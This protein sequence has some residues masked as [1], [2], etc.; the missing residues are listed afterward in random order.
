ME[1]VLES[2]L[3][4]TV[5]SLPGA[6]L[7]G[8]AVATRWQ[9]VRKRKELEL[10]AAQSFYMQY[11]EF[12]AI[13]KIWDQLIED[14]KGDVG[15]VSDV[16]RSQLLERASAMEGGIEATLLK[17][18]SE[19]ALCKR[20]RCHLGQLRQ[21]FGVVRYCIRHRM[22]IPYY[23]SDVDLYLRLKRLSTTFGVLLARPLAH[24]PL[25]VFPTIP[26]PTF[27]EAFEAWRDITSNEHETNWKGYLRK[28]RS[29]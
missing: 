14:A 4:I 15:A 26:A 11:G 19:I 27:E 18:A 23:A 12:F 2:K 6:W 22:E 10:E 5:I 21:A 17:V 29:A 25:S 3:L 13:W 16:T 20:D 28:L 1:A 24:S 7:V 8:N 9:L